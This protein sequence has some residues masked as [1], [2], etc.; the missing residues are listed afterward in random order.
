[1]A[2][3]PAG[4]SSLQVLQP[5]RPRPALLREI[6]HFPAGPERGVSG[7]VR[8]GGAEG[9]GCGEVQGVRD[10]LWWIRGVSD[11]G[12]VAGGSGEG[13]DC[14]LWNWVYGGAEEGT[15]RKAREECDGDFLAGESK[16][17]P[18]TAESLYIQVRSSQMGP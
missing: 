18:A 1:M 9:I 7:E 11:G 13:G 15:L 16:E 10:Q 3:P 6:T 4:G 2:V 14:K 17:S 5:I 8:G 12:D